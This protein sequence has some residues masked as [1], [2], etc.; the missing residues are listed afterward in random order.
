[1]LTILDERALPRSFGAGIAKRASS[2]EDALLSL[3]QRSSS[4]GGVAYLLD[5]TQMITRQDCPGRGRQVAF[6]ASSR[7]DAARVGKDAAKRRGQRSAGMDRRGAAPTECHRQ[8]ISQN[9][10]VSCGGMSKLE[11][12]QFRCISL[13]HLYSAGTRTRRRDLSPGIVETVN[14]YRGRKSPCR[15]QSTRSTIFRIDLR[16]TNGP[17]NLGHLSGGYP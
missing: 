14:T 4:E 2:R 7:R 5:A 11:D 15:R 13:T 12:D 17:S 6:S 10:M 1:M 8:I 9:A 3:P 16:V